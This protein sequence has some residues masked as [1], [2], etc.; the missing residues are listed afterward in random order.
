MENNINVSEGFIKDL[1]SRRPSA[2]KIEA[3]EKKQDKI[4]G[5]I[6]D[7]D[8]KIKELE[9]EYDENPKA[10][11]NKIK[12]KILALTVKKDK[13]EKKYHKRKFD[14]IENSY[15]QQDDT[16]ESSALKEDFDFDKE[17]QEIDSLLAEAD[18]ELN[19]DLDGNKI[20]KYIT[21]VIKKILEDDTTDEYLKNIISQIKDEVEQP[22]VNVQRL[23]EL[24]FK[25]GI[26]KK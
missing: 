26:W 9:K 4:A 22:N 16:L 24:V 13:L 5:K 19:T 6:N 14:K 21:P 11:V 12:R 18:E 23:N 15:E 25:Y 20:N 1:F 8:S 17:M 2:K 7:L 3:L 10:N